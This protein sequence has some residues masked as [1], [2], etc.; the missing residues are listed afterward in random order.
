[1]AT[2]G[3]YTYAPTVNELATEVFDLL[4]IG[5]DGEDLSGDMFNRFKNT[6]NAFLKSMQAQNLHLWTKKEGS[7]FLKKGQE[8]YDFRDSSTHLSNEWF[9][10]T[11][12]AATTAGAYSFTVASAAN[13]LAG[14][15]IGI[16]QDDNDL[17]WTT[18]VR[19]SSLTVTVTDPITNATV[20]GA[21]VRNYRDTFI[22]VSR[23]TS[24]RRRDTSGYEIPVVFE[25]REDFFNLP[26]KTSSGTVIQAYYDRQDVAG[27]KYGVMYVWN[28]P[29]SSDSVI[30]FTYERKMQIITDPDETIDIAEDAQEMFI[31]NV[32]KRLIYKYG[33]SP[34]RAMMIRQ[35]A[36]M[37]LN[38][39]LSVGDSYPVKVKVRTRA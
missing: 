32:A 29:S 36:E 3:N 18:V 24:V 16:I 26:N 6:A 2:S 37:L 35:D 38:D 1:M 33:C 23:V 8:K 10:T 13:I 30:N 4:Q 21:Y 15:T 9:E 12:T 19:V 28:S 17:F 25:S 11:T 34:E 31:F 39:A 27:E 5:S 22:P 14:D 7:L 20:S